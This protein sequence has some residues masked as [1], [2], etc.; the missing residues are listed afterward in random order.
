MY[1]TDVVF[2]TCMQHH[3]LHL[4]REFGM[5]ASWNFEREQPWLTM[6]C[7]NASCLQPGNGLGLTPT[8]YWSLFLSKEMG[9]FWQC[10]FLCGAG[11]FHWR[12]FIQTLAKPVCA[13]SCGLMQPYQH[14]CSSI[15]NSIM[16]ALSLNLVL[17][18]NAQMS[19]FLL[20][21]LSLLQQ[22]LPRYALPGLT[23]D[24]C[25]KDGP[26]LPCLFPPSLSVTKSGRLCRQRVTWV[27]SL[28]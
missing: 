21:N 11:F 24:Y 28:I 20:R 16:I 23:A 14:W 3:Q 4:L 2:S 13:F 1:T 25:R 19:K 10:C 27:S 18:S 8:Q 17:V 9:L 6:L 12:W 5:D 15:F 7:I 22:S 26:T